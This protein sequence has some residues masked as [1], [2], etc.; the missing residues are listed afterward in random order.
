MDRFAVQ[1]NHFRDQFIGILGHDL[2]T[3]LGA[4]TVGAALLALPEDNSQ[5]RSWVVTRIMTSAQRMERV[6]GDLLDV[7]PRP[8]GWINSAQATGRRSSTGLPGGGH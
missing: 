3:P 8:I 4:I 2:R 5:R 7:T 6:I 1:S